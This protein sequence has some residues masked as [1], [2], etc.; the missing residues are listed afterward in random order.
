MKNKY[1]KTIS[2]YNCVCA[3]CGDTISKGEEIII[4]PLAKKAYHVKCRR[5]QY[6]FIQDITF[7]NFD[8]LL[9]DFCKFHHCKMQCRYNFRIYN[10]SQIK[11]VG[12]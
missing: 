1:K 5:K 11:V 12:Y 6:Y 8:D 4:N 9:I 2:K 10:R 7:H 3:T